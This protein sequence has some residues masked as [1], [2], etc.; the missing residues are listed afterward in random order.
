MLFYSKWIAIVICTAPIWA[1]LVQHVWELRVKP[2]LIPDGEIA[3]MADHLVSKHGLEAD[4]QAY[5][6]Q[7]EAWMDGDMVQQGI[8]QRVR[9]ELSRR[10]VFRQS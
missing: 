4:S 6:L 5:M 7:I 9:G 2:R 3:D 10:D 8:L 1:T